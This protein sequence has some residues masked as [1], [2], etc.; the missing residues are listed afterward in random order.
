MKFL[1]IGDIVGRPGREAIKGIIPNLKKEKKYDLIIANCENLTHGKGASEKDLKEMRAAGIDFFTSGNHIWRH[2]SLLSKMDDPD[3]PLIRPENFPQGVPGKGHKIIE[4]SGKKVLIMN[5][6]GRIFMP[7]HTDCP[8][9]TA[10]KILHEVKKENLS[11]IIVDFHAEASSEKV[12]FGY[13][14][15]GKASMVLGTHTHVPTAD[16]RILQGGT[17]YITDAGMTGKKDSVIGVDKEGIIDHFLTQ[18]PAKHEITPD[19][20]SIMNA[21]EFEVDPETQ[22]T[23]HIQPILQEYVESK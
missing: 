9:E 18:L 8:F 22:K 21:V 16:F 20:V 23:I 2:K 19:G 4:V 15:D 1:F 5:L 10:K 17:G 13:F 7:Q 3:M 11:A 14:L 6:I 12:A